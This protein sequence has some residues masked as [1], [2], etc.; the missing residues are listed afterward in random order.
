VNQPS[1]QPRDKPLAAGTLE[2]A[3][4]IAVALV[5]MLIR[6]INLDANPLQPAESA[7]ALDSWRIAQHLGVRLGASPV[8]VYGNA[9]LFIALGATDGVARAIPMA[10]GVIVALLPLFLRRELGRIAALAT[11]LLLATSPTLVFASRSV[12]PTSLTLLLA[13]VLLLALARYSRTRRTSYLY[14]AAIDA[15]LLLMSGPPAYIVLVVLIGYLAASPPPA[16]RALLD[17][18]PDETDEDSSGEDLR[19]ALTGPALAFLATVGIVGTGFGTNLEGFGDALAGPIGRWFT[20]LGGI[21]L[22]SLA[23]LPTILLSYEPYAAV[24]GVVGLVAALRAHRKTDAFF[25]WWAVIAAVLFLVSDGT[26]PTWAAFVVV[27]LSVLAGRATEEILPSIV[28]REGR[29]D[30]IIF[31]AIVLSLLATLLIAVGN[32]TLPD[33]NVPRWAGALPLFAMVAFSVCFGLWSSPRAA[34]TGLAAVGMIA[35]LGVDLHASMMLNPGGPLNPAEVFTGTATSPDVRTLASDVNLTMNELHI[36]R[37]LEGKKVDDTIEI[38]STFENPVAWY[39]RAFSQTQV[40]PSI[41]DVP[42]IAV[43]QADA[44]APS[45]PYAG[46]LFEVTRSATRPGLDPTQII[47]W[48]LYR[49]SP[50]ETLTYAKVFVKT[51]LSRE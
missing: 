3:A 46:V 28:A 1:A 50:T 33:P 4:W 51:Q 8:L 31:G 43:E 5:A 39:L 34:L 16:V 30:R 32:A 38:V 22:E 36:A 2:V 15:A 44:K 49:E 45:G 41:G 29:R 13:A 17:F 7:V 11:A 48:W 24:F 21:T 23:E 27:P 6:V 9:L 20:S 42:G 40:V 14:V 12:E 26:H 35:F 18:S 19:R 37:Q 25:A 10:S 47:R